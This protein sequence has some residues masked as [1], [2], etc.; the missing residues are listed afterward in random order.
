[1]GLGFIFFLRLSPL[2][3]QI[4]VLNHSTFHL[5]NDAANSTDTI[6]TIALTEQASKILT[7]PLCDFH[8]TKLHD[9]FSIRGPISRVIQL[10]KIASGINDSTTKAAFLTTMQIEDSLFF[11][12]KT[13]GDDLSDNQH[14]TEIHWDLKSETY[15]QNTVYALKTSAFDAIRVYMD[16]RLL[17]AE[18]NVDSITGTLQTCYNS[19][20][21]II[22]LLISDT[23][24]HQLSV[25]YINQNFFAET[26]VIMIGDFFSC[27]LYENAVTALSSENHANRNFAHI[28][29]EYGLTYFFYC[30]SILAILFLIFITRS[31]PMIWFC[32]FSL[33][34]SLKLSSDSAQ[35]SSIQ[36]FYL[37]LLSGISCVLYFYSAYKRIPI[38][39]YCY[40][41]FLVTPIILGINLNQTVV[42]WIIQ[43]LVWTFVLST[44]IIIIDLLFTWIK[45]FRRKITGVNVAASG[46]FL[47]F[48]VAAFSVGGHLLKWEIQTPKH[49]TLIAQFYLPVSFVISIMQITRA[50][51][52][53]KERSQLEVIGL[54][55]QN[56]EILQNQNL[57]LEKEVA[58]RTLELQEEKKNVETR[59]TEILDSIEYAK[60]IQNTILP[61]REQLVNSLPASFVL[62]L[63]KD[64]VAGDF[65]WVHKIHGSDSVLVAACDCTGHGVPGAMVSVVCSNALNKTVNELQ[66]SLPSEILD[67]TREEVIRALSRNNLHDD[68]VKDG[69]DASLALI[70]FTNRKLF[71]SG[72]NSPIW[73]SRAGEI[74][75]WAGD[76]Q[77]IGK[78][79]INKPFTLHEMDLLKD[80]CLYLFTDGYQDQFGGERNRKFSKRQLRE[81]IISISRDDI[82]RQK[83]ILHQRLTAWK[84]N[85]EQIDDIC[86]I[87]VK[88]T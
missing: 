51:S 86:I 79:P 74:I 72:A 36:D 84:G 16:N 39:I 6:G 18:G 23:N 88:I 19:K 64:I 78:N 76:K 10:A 41:F 60:R 34:F 13:K 26:G 81:L 66:L 57:Y 69:M 11:R 20:G 77:P 53:E 5:K 38:R 48:L 82:S 49:L 28:S 14:F 71:W 65:Y 22:P 12:L 52:K 56:N 55:K 67:T 21:V 7:A 31:S 32:V 33:S 68:E 29:E 8:R 50:Y 61:S 44:L 37:S 62:Y 75:E 45:N 35:L 24:T 2:H 15:E 85:Q 46:V 70:Q 27:D 40:I 54:T 58:Q 17:Y 87:G 25:R 30:C 59:N 1:M 42:M 3:C 43:P 80:D 83:D 63:P 9:E 4:I 73:I 47:F